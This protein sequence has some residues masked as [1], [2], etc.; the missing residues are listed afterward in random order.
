MSVDRRWVYAGLVV[1]A[2]GVGLAKLMPRGPRVKPGETRL[3]LVGDSLAVGM[4]PHFAYLAKKQQVPFDALA[5]E[6]TR[7]DQW[8]G[9]QV[10]AEHVASFKPTLVLV[11]LGTN[12]AYMVGDVAA[13]QRPALA[14]LI[15]KLTAGGAELAW[16]GPPQLPKKPNAGL[17][18]LLRSAFPSDHY[19]A[20]ETLPIP[21]G[22]DSLHPTARGYAGWAGAVWQWLSAPPGT[23]A[24][25]A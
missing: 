23:G 3:M 6:S 20:S 4:A 11:S 22:P 5:K 8:A 19:F 16:I 9:S 13:K 2:A 10:L 15:A 7:I 21:R 17:L 18:A 25:I 1:A 14:G 24:C 12:D